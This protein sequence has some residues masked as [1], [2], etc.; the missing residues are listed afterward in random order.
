MQIRSVVYI[1]HMIIHVKC[2]DLLIQYLSDLLNGFK[3]YDRLSS[4]S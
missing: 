1:L 2:L 3:F 4:Q